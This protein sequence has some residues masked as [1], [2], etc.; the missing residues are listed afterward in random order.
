MKAKFKGEIDMI[1]MFHIKFI[2]G[3]E[4]DAFEDK[5]H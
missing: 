2:D 1:K 3:Y 4:T 5:L